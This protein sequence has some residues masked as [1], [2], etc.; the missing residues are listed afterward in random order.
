MT[1]LRWGLH[2][3]VLDHLDAERTSR[4]YEDLGCDFITFSES[5]L[6]DADPL[7][8]ATLAAAASESIGL[9]IGTFNPVLRDPATLA[10]AAA[11]LQLRSGS[12]LTVT[13]GTGYTALALLGLPYPAR[14][15]ALEEYSQALRAYLHGRP[16]ARNGRDTQLA[17]LPADYDPPLI[18]M[19]SSGRRSLATAVACADIVCVALGAGRQAIAWSLEQIKH[20]LARVGRTRDEIEIA[21]QLPLGLDDGTPGTLTRGARLVAMMAGF[22]ARSKLVDELYPEYTAAA[23]EALVAMFDDR[24]KAGEILPG[25]DPGIA[26][27]ASAL[28]EAF[29]RS[30]GLIG[31]APTLRGR[32]AELSAAG[33]DRVYFTVPPDGLAVDEKQ[34]LLTRVATDLFNRPA[35]PSRR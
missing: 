30:F 4:I 15:A 27:A 5:P 18:E 28:P 23:G 8:Q 20:E 19:V 6:K 11:T 9:R 21:V 26:D 1:R 12:R 10:A 17:W 34:A 33:V 29:V 14:L 35:S 24:G 31:D 25:T 7:V 13:L 2:G 22:G 32:L 16:T 3:T